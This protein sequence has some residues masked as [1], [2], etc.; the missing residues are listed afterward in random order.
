[1]RVCIV[2]DCLYPYTV[3]GAERWYGALAR[4]LAA[5]GHEVTYL[6]RRQWD[7]A[8]EPD[9]P[10]VRVVAVSPGGPLYTEDGRRT[11]RSPL[12][13]GLGVL[14]HLLRHRGAYDAVHTCAFPYFSL[15]A[16]RAALAG[17]RV[18]LSVDWFEVWSRAYWS[19]YLGGVG[20][21]IGHLVQK[22]CVRL[23]PRAF[24]FSRLYA[25]RLREE[26]L[27]GPV[28]ELAGLYE[29]EG[30]APGGGE[31]APLV[32]FAGRHIPEKRVPAIPPA[33]ASARERVPE[34]RGLIL[35]DGPDRPRVLEEIARLGLDGVV[36]AP[37]FVDVAE[38]D[39]ALSRASCHVLPSIRE[40]Y[41]LVVIEAAAAGTPSVVARAPDNAAVELIAED[42][43]GLVAAS[44][45]PPDLVEAIVRVH[46]AG[47]TLRAA[48]RAWFEANAARLSLDASLAEV[49]DSY[50]DRA[51]R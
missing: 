47:E 41:G 14:G 39:A 1:M 20:G 32:V 12:R 37:G 6:T 15:L 45:E 18:A 34:L 40:G 25:A 17:R 28:S 30:A 36:E 21:R 8:G 33:I 10:G 31:R 38:V 23:T 46:E 44:P 4:R 49:V 51:R 16:A 50:S 42:E 35:G 5:A 48:T 19:E 29:G 3:G 22:L 27:R 2:Y 24:V 11:I 43:N 7:E 13:F 9:I 26:G